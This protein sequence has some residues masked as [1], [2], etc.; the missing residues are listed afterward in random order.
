MADSLKIFKTLARDLPDNLTQL[1]ENYRLAY[2]SFM[3]KTGMPFYISGICENIAGDCEQ[4]YLFKHRLNFTRDT[5]LF[6][7]K[8]HKLLHRY[9][10]L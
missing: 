2:G 1:T 5:Q 7:E 6:T 10:V 3:D 9:F 4:G 8:V